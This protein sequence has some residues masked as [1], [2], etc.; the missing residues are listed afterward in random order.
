VTPQ[1][2][3]RLERW[4]GAGHCLPIVARVRQHQDD[5]SDRGV[6]LLQQDR[7]HLRLRVHETSH[8]LDGN[9]TGGGLQQSVERA[10][11]APGNRGLGTPVPTGACQTLAETREE[12]ELS[13]VGQHAL[14]DEGPN[15]NVEPH[16][17]R[18]ARQPN[19]AG[20][21]LPADLDSADQLSRA[22]GRPSHVSLR[23]AGEQP[24]PAN[25]GADCLKL[26]TDTPL[27][28]RDGIVSNGH[29]HILA[30]GSLAR[31]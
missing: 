2:E 16:D 9:L 25:L 13:S 10:P 30:S 19:D 11:V 8:R 17:R 1:G 31:A 7:A 4:L 3:G 15:R 26:R 23:D 5:T 29:R 18:N 20:V 14:A 22:A 6:P 27:G 28:I 21:G 24:S 12:L